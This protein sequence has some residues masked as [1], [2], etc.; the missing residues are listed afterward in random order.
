MLLV[1]FSRTCFST[2]TCNIC[3]CNSRNMTGVTANGCELGGFKLG[4]IV[5]YKLPI[6]KMKCRNRRVM[7]PIFNTSRRL[8]QQASRSPPRP[9]KFRERKSLVELLWKGNMV[10]EHFLGLGPVSAKGE[11][12]IIRLDKDNGGGTAQEDYLKSRLRG[13]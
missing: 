4:V 7:I 8:H 12:A 10:L 11:P 2:M 6:P 3:F 9:A 13:Q 1:Y 5:D